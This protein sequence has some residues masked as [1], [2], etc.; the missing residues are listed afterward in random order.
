M[1][2]M[3]FTYYCVFTLVPD[4]A[5]LGKE[6]GAATLHSSMSSFFYLALFFWADYIFN[7]FKFLNTTTAL[8]LV[9]LIFG[10]HFIFNWRY[11]LRQDKQ[12]ELSEKYGDIKK[13]KRKLIGFAYLTFCFF[14]FI[15]SMITTGILQR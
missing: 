1:K 15:F 14:F 2:A 6:T 8:I 13:W 10:G 4:K 7:G 12:K 3:E 5:T 9:V 11:F